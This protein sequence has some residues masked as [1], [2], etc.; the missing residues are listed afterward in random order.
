VTRAHI[1]ER[2]I[3]CSVQVEYQVCTY[4]EMLDQQTKRKQMLKSR[5]GQNCIYAPCMTVYLVIS[6]PK[7][8]NIKYKWFWPTLLKRRVHIRAGENI[9]NRKS[10]RA[11]HL[12]RWVCVQCEMAHVEKHVC[13]AKCYYR[14]KQFWVRPTPKVSGHGT[15]TSSLGNR[16]KGTRS[17]QM[18]YTE[19]GVLTHAGYER[20]IGQ[21]DTCSNALVSQRRVSSATGTHGHASPPASRRVHTQCKETRI[22]QRTCSCKGTCEEEQGTRATFLFAIP[23]NIVK[24]PR[25]AKRC[26]SD[27]KFDTS[28]HNSLFFF[29]TLWLTSQPH[30]LFNTHLIPWSCRMSSRYRSNTFVIQTTISLK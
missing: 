13:I 16:R 21:Q 9:K 10:T 24:G 6:L 19:E 11:T 5:V 30:V 26:W 29:S 15:N 25:H 18:Q 20:E 23:G 1:R 28:H 4:S 3:A 12:R 2:R 22:V 14:R 27:I 8:P 17:L 7:I